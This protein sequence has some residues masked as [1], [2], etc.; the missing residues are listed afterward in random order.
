M[1][2]YEQ[3]G[4]RKLGLNLIDWINWVRIYQFKNGTKI[5]KNLLKPKNDYYQINSENFKAPVY[6]RNNISDFAIFKQVFYENQYDLYD[7]DFPKAFTILDAGANI[8]MAAVYFTLKFPDASIIAVE[9]ERNNY[10]LLVKN[11][12]EYTNIKCLNNAIWDKN[13]P[14]VITNPDSLAAGFI[15]EETKENSALNF[16]GITVNAIMQKNGW[17]NI[18]I[19]KM[20]IEGA[21]KEVFSAD[22]LAWLKKVK[23]LIVELH[24]RYKPGTTKALFKAL[25]SLEYEAYFH[26]ENIFIFF[27][28]PK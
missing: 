15:V 27:N 10:E 16:Q 2:K 4:L 9:P 25:D 18:D 21:E 20:D 14:L 6:L 3:S 24:D 7:K 23:L 1:G 5:F 11:T 22:D 19:V 26:H 28:S 8:G 13:E 17:E 12:R